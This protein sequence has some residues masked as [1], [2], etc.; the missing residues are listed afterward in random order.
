MRSKQGLN[1]KRL[2]CTLL[3]FL[4]P[5]AAYADE[6][7]R[8]MLPSE[9]VAYIRIV[10]P[11]G[12]NGVAPGTALQQAFE[13]SGKELDIA[14]SFLAGFENDPKLQLEAPWLEL[15]YRLRAPT[16]AALLLSPGKPIQAANLLMRTRLDIGSITLAN[17]FF[18]R[19]ASVDKALAVTE[20]L[21]ARGVGILNWNQA[22]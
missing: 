13:D 1:M 15:L 16:E 17:E 5:V 12:F 7:L 8:S 3:I 19:L 6:T 20:A 14:Q 2:F 4:A 22:V 10:G 21:D 18:K 11:D 9:A